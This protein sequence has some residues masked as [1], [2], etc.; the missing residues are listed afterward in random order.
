[1]IVKLSLGINK[2]WGWKT[3][4]RLTHS[5]TMLSWLDHTGLQLR[6]SPPLTQLTVY[7]TAQAKRTSARSVKH[8]DSWQ[9]C[10][11]KGRPEDCSSDSHK[12]T[13]FSLSLHWLFSV[14]QKQVIPQ[15]TLQLR[16]KKM[17]LNKQRATVNWIFGRIEDQGSFSCKENLMPLNGTSTRSQGCCFRVVHEGAVLCLKKKKS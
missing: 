4:R 12:K 15:A 13:H 17:H 6:L 9:T 14:E 16:E 10:R 3:I 7:S 2:L 1:M 5:T 8:T 11:K